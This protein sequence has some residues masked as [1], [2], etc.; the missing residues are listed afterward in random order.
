MAIFTPPTDNFVGTVVPGAEMGNYQLSR[1]KKFA[2]KLGK[3]LPTRPRGRN[4]YL[5]ANG[6]ITEDQPGDMDTVSKVYLGGHN[7]VIDSDEV[8]TL[9]AAGYGA[10]IS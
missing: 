9:T 4:V 2:N 5:L 3:H 10:Y 6:Q 1:A 7:N 8:A